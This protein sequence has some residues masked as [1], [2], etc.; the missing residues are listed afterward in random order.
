MC[1]EDGR[2]CAAVSPRGQRPEQLPRCEVIL[3]RKAFLNIRCAVKQRQTA[4][5]HLSC[6]C[7]WGEPPTHTHIRTSAFEHTL[8]GQWP[9][10]RSLSSVIQ[11]IILME[12]PESIKEQKQTICVQWELTVCTVNMWT[13]TL[14]VFH[15]ES[16]MI[17][18]LKTQNIQRDANRQKEV[19]HGDVGRRHGS[20]VPRTN[21]SLWSM[22]CWPVE[23]SLNGF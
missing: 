15:L 18:V 20:P 2:V 23:S 22:I 8:G 10:S 6:V 12:L 17:Y 5:T 13:D 11:I 16:L 4:D 19:H 14:I 9:S 7:L 3:Q 1:V 21:L